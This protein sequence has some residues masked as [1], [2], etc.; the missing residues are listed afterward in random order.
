MFRPG[1]LYTH[2]LML[3]AAIYVLKSFRVFD[4]RYKLKIRWMLR[5]GTDLRVTETVTITTNQLSRWRK[6]A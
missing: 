1:H 2:E 6:I 3:D 4:G 5:N